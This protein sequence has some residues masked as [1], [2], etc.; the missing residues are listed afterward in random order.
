M[1]CESGDYKEAAS[2]LNEIITSNEL[3]QV[4]EIRKSASE[5]LI[6]C[7]RDPGIFGGNI[8]H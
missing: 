6:D 8:S 7:A 2:I 4:F 3:E 1:T 5:D